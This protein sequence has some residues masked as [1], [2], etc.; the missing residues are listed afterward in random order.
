MRRGLVLGDGEEEEKEEGEE[1]RPGMKCD[2]GCELDSNLQ[3][4]V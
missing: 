4:N 2:K 1:G 3:C